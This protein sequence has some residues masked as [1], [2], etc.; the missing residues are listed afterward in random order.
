MKNTNLKLN[1]TKLVARLM[2]V[3]I[4]IVGTINLTGCVKSQIGKGQFFDQTSIKS[5]ISLR[6]IS[7]TQEF[8]L[9]DVTFQ[10]NIGLHKKEYSLFHWTTTDTKNLLSQTYDI[11]EE[12]YDDI[13]YIIYLENPDIKEVYRDDMIL[14]NID[15]LKEI[16]YKESLKDGKYNYSRMPLFYE[17][18]YNYSESITIPKEYFVQ[19]EYNTIY[20]KLCMVEKINGEYHYRN[21]EVK[22]GFDYNIR[23]NGTLY[24]GIPNIK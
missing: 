6:V 21:Q 18:Y 2:L 11:S 5:P 12:V 13:Y 9:N 19:G 17:T 22:L 3:V 7:D 15:V 23:D 8:E 10:L 24:I 14:K 1:K 20:I 4:L 16:S